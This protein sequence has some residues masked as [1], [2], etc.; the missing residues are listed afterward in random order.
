LL[1]IEALWMKSEGVCRRQIHR[2]SGRG[3]AASGPQPDF[4]NWVWTKN[5][6]RDFAELDGKGRN[7][8]RALGWFILSAVMRGG[9]WRLSRAG[10]NATSRSGW[11]RRTSRSSRPSLVGTRTS[12]SCNV[13]SFSKTT[14]GIRPP[15]SA[16]SRCHRGWRGR[17]WRTSADA[18]AIGCPAK[19]AGKA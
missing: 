14:R 17:W 5:F 12:K 6:R 2:H 1:R 10:S 4:R 8:S 11:V 13:A 3:S 16:L 7:Y 9:G 19:A 15:A 18:N